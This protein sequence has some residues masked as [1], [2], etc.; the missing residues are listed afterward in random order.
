MEYKQIYFFSNLLE[1]YYISVQCLLYVNCILLA[2]SNVSHL[3]SQQHILI[4]NVV[5]KY[6]FQSLL[7]RIKRTTALAVCPSLKQRKADLV[8]IAIALCT[9]WVFYEMWPIKFSE[10]FWSILMNSAC[11]NYLTTLHTK[12]IVAP[13]SF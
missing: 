10:K 2:C 5:F 12:I 3:I 4:K 6:S 13:F 9:L 1:Y 7:I 11:N 8:C